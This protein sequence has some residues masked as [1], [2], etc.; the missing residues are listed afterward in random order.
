MDNS[1]MVPFAF[2][3]PGSPVPFLTMLPV[4]NLPTETGN[5]DGST[6]NFDREE[7][8]D[9]SHKNQSDQ[10]FD[11]AESLD[12][13]EI[14]S[15]S[16]STKHSASVDPSEE[17]CDH[18]TDILHSDFASHWQNLQ[19]GRFCQ[20]PRYHGPPIYPS[21]VMVPSA[22]LQG[23]IPWEGPGRP[24]SPNGNIVSQ[25]M[26]YGPHLV[27]V[28]PFQPGSNRPTSVYQRYGD[29]LPRYRSGTGTY[30]PN[31]KVSL[32]D[33][34]S[35]N[36]RNQR[37]N[38]NYD[39]ND[40]HSDR[41]GNWNNNTRPRA[42]GRN[43]NRSQVDRLSPRSDRLASSESRVDRPW[44]SF[45]H[46]SFPSHQ[47]QNGPFGSSNITNSVPANVAYGM[48]PLQ[49][50]NSN[51]VAPSVVMLYPYDHNGG[52]GSPPEQLEFGTL[53]PIHISGT[54]EVSQLGE[55]GLVRGVYEH[56]KFQGG[57]PAYSS[58]DQP[59]SPQLQR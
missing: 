16:C 18:N 7:T 17:P 1:G 44:D 42:S 38:Y 21:P 58:P 31:T 45:R 33:R 26:S 5:S 15:S 4:F 41:E 34:H 28:A 25:L 51:G 57:S 32:K 19:Y 11:S 39:H 53:G 14:F 13:S 6:N 8:M 46:D 24:V 55:R 50:V 30:L 47:S 37:G 36:S 35:S 54:N 59:S 22:Y 27:S 2:Y 23:H 43:Y 40:R 52:Y 3:L 48:Y 10:N 9:K 29:E 12:Q 56:Q 20:N 49:A